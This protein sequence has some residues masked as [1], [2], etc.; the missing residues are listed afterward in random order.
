MY[1]GAAGQARVGDHLFIH[2][3]WGSCPSHDLKVMPKCPF[4]LTHPP[5]QVAL[6]DM[7]VDSNGQL[8]LRSA[9]STA[10]DSGNIKVSTALT[11]LSGCPLDMSDDDL[12]H[13]HM[14]QVLC[15]A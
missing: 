13:M 1:P 11:S 3:Q 10:A 15:L 5:T 7:M 12:M 4:S 6:S 2:S 14:I 9:S 8:V